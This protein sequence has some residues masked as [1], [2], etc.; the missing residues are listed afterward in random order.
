MKGFT[1]E[2]APLTP[3]EVE[4]L[5]MMM[6]MGGSPLWGA[7]LRRLGAMRDAAEDSARSAIE[8]RDEYM[9]ALRRAENALI[10]PL[11]WDDTEA[12]MF[13]DADGSPVW[14]VE[15]D[16]DG[17]W[18]AYS[19]DN[20]LLNHRGYLTEEDAKRAC[21]ARHRDLILST[22]AIPEAEVSDDASKR[23]ERNG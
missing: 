6:E 8:Q 5:A 12:G 4:A 13:G 15:R 7:V 10:A 18:A 21:E 14:N 3:L 19:D 11:T 20:L 2:T 17:S 16:F 1:V 22:L 23:T 9:T